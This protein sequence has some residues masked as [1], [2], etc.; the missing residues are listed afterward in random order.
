MRYFKNNIP[1]EVAIVYPWKRDA[2]WM[3]RDSGGKERN[4]YCVR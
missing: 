3:W 2:E 4:K 1:Y